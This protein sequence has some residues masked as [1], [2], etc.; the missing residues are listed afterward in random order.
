MKAVSD[1]HSYVLNLY[2]K[3]S[4]D[5]VRKETVLVSLYFAHLFLFCVVLLPS[6]YHL[7]P[8][9]PNSVICDEKA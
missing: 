7:F 9:R 1:V 2:T 3:F 4:T 8:S 5:P 6:R